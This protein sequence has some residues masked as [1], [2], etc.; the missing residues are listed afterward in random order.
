MPQDPGY[1]ETDEENGE[2]AAGLHPDSL[3]KDEN[4]LYRP[5]TTCNKI[6]HNYPGTKF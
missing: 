3:K 4:G 6:T 5:N 2:M 1:A